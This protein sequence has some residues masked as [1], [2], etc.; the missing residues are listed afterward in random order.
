MKKRHFLFLFFL[1]ICFVK[2]KAQE[3]SNHEIQIKVCLENETRA[4]IKRDLNSGINS[5]AQFP[6]SGIAW[7]NRDGSFFNKKG[8]DNIYSNMKESIQNDPKERSDV[9][10]N[11][12]YN[13]KL[14]NYEWAWVS[15]DQ[16]IKRNENW[17]VNTSEMRLMT[18]IGNEWKIVSQISLWDYS[19]LFNNGYQLTNQLGKIVQHST[20]LGSVDWLIETNL[21]G[22][23]IILFP[24][25]LPDNLKKSNL[26]IEFD[27][28]F[29]YGKHQLYKP[30]S[31]GKPTPDNSVNYVRID[32]VK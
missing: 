30:G 12:N 25:G 8:W 4:W 22:N 13:I 26:E 3:Y 32:K 9:F 5:W 31:G 24:I 16:E 29:L 15:Y 19:K 27:G 6:F 14:L 28:E 20:A 10:E 2:V 17:K 11:R 18:K 23:I 7:N 21:F 1:S